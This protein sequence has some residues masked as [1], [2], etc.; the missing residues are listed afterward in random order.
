MREGILL[1]NWDLI[2]LGVMLTIMSIGLAL[3][4]I[5]DKFRAN[6]AKEQR[7]PEKYR[8]IPY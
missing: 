7:Q 4:P 3:K 1:M 8:F 6:R 5:F 2:W